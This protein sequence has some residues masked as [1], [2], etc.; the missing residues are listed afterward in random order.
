[1]EISGGTADESR[2]D[3][4]PDERVVQLDG[5]PLGGPSE[6]VEAAAPGKVKKAKTVAVQD[7]IP[8]ESAAPANVRTP[9]EVIKACQDVLGSRCNRACRSASARSSILT[10]SGSCAASAAC[11][12]RGAE[13][14]FN[15]DEIKWLDETV[16][17]ASKTVT[18]IEAIHGKDGLLS[19]ASSST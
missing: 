19:K 14:D 15:D 17:D 3:V 2:R 8:E 4:R 13:A 12:G 6:V 9:N 5:Q 7:S 1:M 10:S 16:K 11:A 18:W